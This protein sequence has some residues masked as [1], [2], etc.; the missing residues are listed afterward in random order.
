MTK[1]VNGLL[2]LRLL[3][4]CSI[5]IGLFGKLFKHCDSQ[6]FRTII[7]RFLDQY[8]NTVWIL[9]SW[10]SSLDVT[11]CHMS[12]K[13]AE[14][15]CSLTINRLVSD[16]SKLID[17]WSWKISFSKSCWTQLKYFIQF[18]WYMGINLPLD[19]TM[20]QPI[21]ELFIWYQPWVLQV[22]AT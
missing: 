1:P 13:L 22:S 7:L 21:V 17:L 14:K 10:I 3:F 15:F 11:K 4:I 19:L 16:L 5:V 2:I 18:Y 6:P 20:I 9:Y 8:E 12:L